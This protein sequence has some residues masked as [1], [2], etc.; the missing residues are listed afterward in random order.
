MDLVVLFDKQDSYSLGDE[1]LEKWQK[2]VIIILVIISGFNLFL[3][4]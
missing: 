1:I 2:K 4:F 3:F